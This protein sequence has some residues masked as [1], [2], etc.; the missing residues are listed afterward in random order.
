M[1]TLSWARLGANVTGLDFSE[2][3]VKA[4]WD[5]SRRANIDAIFIQNDV[6]DADT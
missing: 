3:A 4:A 2:V 6:Y 5:L 1:D